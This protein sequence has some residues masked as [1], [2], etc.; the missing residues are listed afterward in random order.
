MSG[1]S[2]V[3]GKGV[4]ESL[5]ALNSLDVEEAAGKG[6]GEIRS[7]LSET[8]YRGSPGMQRQAA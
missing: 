1:G 8:G 2:K 5:S 3:I 7:M 4:N 6:S